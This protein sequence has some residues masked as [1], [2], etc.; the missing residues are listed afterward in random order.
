MADSQRSQTCGTNLEGD[1]LAYCLSVDLNDSLNP[2]PSLA[3]DNC[4]TTGDQSCLAELFNLSE[5]GDSKFENA[6]KASCIKNPEINT[7][8][9]PAIILN[10]CNDD[11][12]NATP[13][14]RELNAFHTLCLT[15]RTT[16][17]I[18]QQ[19]C[20]ANL[21]VSDK[22]GDTVTLAC[23]G[24]Q[25]SNTVTANPFNSLCYNGDT[26]QTAREMLVD[27]CEGAGIAPNNSSCANVKLL[28]CAGTGEF[29]NPFVNLCTDLGNLADLQHIKCLT[30]DELS[31]EFH[32]DCNDIID[33]GDVTRNVWQYDDIPIIRPR[34]F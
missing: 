23:T 20:L 1:I 27:T 25:G 18:R 22:C 4:G 3:A 5:C 11:A 9:C 15:D 16:D 2:P 29:S 17:T 8:L 7:T 19:A 34:L 21:E 14:N 24:Q 31:D 6:R 26:Y 28:I 33:N 12:F 32:T 13:A 30:T 10:Y